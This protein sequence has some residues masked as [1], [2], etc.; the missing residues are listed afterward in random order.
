MLVAIGFSFIGDIV[1]VANITVFA[2]V[3]T[4][5][6]INLSV[7][8]LRYTEPNIERKFRIPVNIGKFPVLPLFGLII[9]AYMAFQFEMEVMLVGF[10]IIVIGIMFYV[11]FNRKSSKDKYPETIR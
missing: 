2:V 10:G 9:S 8:I 6:A 11:I 5:G 4:F 7:I 1:I 3:I